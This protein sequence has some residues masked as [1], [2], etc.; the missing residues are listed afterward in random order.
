MLRLTNIF[1]VLG[2]ATFMACSHMTAVEK[3]DCLDHL[4]MAKGFKPYNG[5]ALGCRFFIDQ[6]ECNGELLFALNCH[7]A[8]IIYKVIDCDNNDVTK[9]YGDKVFNMKAKIV[10][11]RED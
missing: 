11:F 9:E 2:I 5:E 10:A 8:D 3:Q 6:Y 1:C 4:E 7:C